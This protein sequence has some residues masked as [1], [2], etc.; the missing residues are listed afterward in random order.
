MFSLTEDQVMIQEMARDFAKQKIAPTVLERDGKHE[1]DRELVAAI[2]NMGLAG[3]C[4]PE[5]YGGADAGYLSYILAV[6]ELSR[7][8]DGIGITLSAN[9]SLCAYPIY[10]F[11]TDAQKEKY[12]TPIAAG[13]KLGAFGLTE[14]DAGTDAAGQQSVAVLNGDHYVLNGSKAFITNGGE[15]E[16]Y[17]VFAMTDKSKGNKG[18]TAF[19]LEKGM[20]GFSFGKKEHKLGIHTSLTTGLIFKDVRVPLENRLG[21]EGEGFKIAMKTLDGGRIKSI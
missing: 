2:G 15:A 20:E 11:G 21:E 14:P 13:E 19:I 3:L 18:I 1:F 7:I 8:D 9:V 16:T 6:E 10:E 12:L 17:V 4:F 5:E